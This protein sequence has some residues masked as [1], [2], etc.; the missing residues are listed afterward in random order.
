[1]HRRIAEVGA[2]IA[3]ALLLLV[4]GSL[5]TPPSPAQAVT[6]GP[7]GESES[8]PGPGHYSGGF[9]GTL[10]RTLGGRFISGEVTAPVG[11]LLEIDIDEAGHVTGLASPP[12]PDDAG[13]SPGGIN[14]VLDG[15]LPEPLVGADVPARGQVQVN[16][17]SGA[18][19]SLGDVVLHFNDF[20]RELCAA[21]KGSWTLES[22][23]GDDAA[24]RL[25]LRD[26]QWAAK[27]VDFNENVEREIRGGAGQLASLPP[28]QALGM[29][30]GLSREQADA[31]IDDLVA[32]TATPSGGL[33]ALY[34]K[35]Q[36]AP[37]P[38]AQVRCLVDFVQTVI[39][40]KLQEYLAAGATPAYEE[41]ARYGHVVKVAEGVGAGPTCP[42]YVGGRA[43]LHDLIG[44]V[45]Q[46]MMGD[47]SDV[48]GV[49]HLTRE[50][51]TFG[52]D[53]LYQAGKSWL[54]QRGVAV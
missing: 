25:E 4:P 30:E 14:A 33:F 39:S 35:A 28:A 23:G 45:L 49:T 32:G 29:P 24:G 22:I 18:S 19:L 46:A 13:G 21:V 37:A 2:R 48:D 42:A 38:A 5:L 11:G 41:A 34:Q 9:K 10:V 50:A 51:N 3:V 44:A 53:D 15:Q 43:G 20:Q 52:F 16:F 31:L 12:P 17:S 40:L 47:G 8:L 36:A 6:S 1:M 7:C 54:A 27:L 26:A